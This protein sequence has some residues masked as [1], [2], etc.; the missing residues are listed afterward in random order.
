MR[1][2]A[3]GVAAALRALAPDL[4]CVQEAP[5]LFGWRL[6]R[7]LLA[8][9]SGLRVLTRGRA[10]GNLLLAAPGVR[11]LSSGTVHLPRRRGLHRRAVVHARVVVDGRELVLAGTH[12]DVEPAARLD[13]ARRVR[14]G[15]PAGRLVL[16]ADVNDVPGSPAWQALAAGLV[17]V[18]GQA[19]TFPVHAPGRRI[20]ALLLDPGL[21]VESAG[22]EAT[23]PV[24]DHLAVRA[25]L[26]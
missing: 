9:R 26:R 10:C 23:G 11:V 1:D 12:L 5:R 7:R 8:R 18:G 22:V 6:S 14:A 13:S 24:S 2:D 20:D 15:L 4:V 16:G 17:S 19:P 21:F 3:R 25:D